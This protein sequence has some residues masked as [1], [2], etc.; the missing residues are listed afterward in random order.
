MGFSIFLLFFHSFGSAHNSL[1]SSVHKGCN[2]LP[3]ASGRKPILSALGL[4]LKCPPKP[5]VLKARPVAGVLLRSDRTMRIRLLGREA[6][7]AIGLC[8][9]T[10]F[11]CV[12]LHHRQN[13]DPRRKY[14]QTRSSR[15]MS[16]ILFSKGS[17][18]TPGPS[19]HY[20]VR[21]QSGC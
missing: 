14:A 11:S 5:R 4:N 15:I 12:L 6:N 18:V 1:S 17:R 2:W 20:T 19:S 10:T 8:P 13:H 3:L 9:H 21:Q 16:G 7:M